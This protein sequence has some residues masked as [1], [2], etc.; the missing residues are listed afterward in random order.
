MKKY[1]KP[2]IIF[3]VILFI[4]FVPGFIFKAQPDYYKSLNKPFYAPPALL[5]GIAWPV[6]FVIFSVFITRKI[7]NNSL[8]LD[9]VMY[10]I[11]NYFLTFFFNKI[12]FIDHNLLFTLIDTILCF[13]SIGLLFLNI[14]KENKNESWFLLPYLI[15]TGFASILM[16]HIYFLA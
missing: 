8:K 15:W 10:L 6:L 5:F 13:V 12:F 1:L 3:A 9:Q 7:L 2:I 14:W 4:Y 16:T 11:I